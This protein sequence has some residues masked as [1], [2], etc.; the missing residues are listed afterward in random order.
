MEIAE[1]FKALRRHRFLVV[2]VVL[3]AIAAAAGMKL[4]SHSIPTGTATAQILIDSPQSAL[5]DLEQNTA[6]LAVRASVFA[7]LM[8][9]GAVLQ[10]IAQKAGVPPNE[11]TAEGPYSGTGQVLD[12]PT[13]SEA[14]GSQV[15]SAKILYRLTFV[16]QTDLPVI[17]VSAEGPSP[18]AAGRLANSVTP[19]V[20]SWL[21]TVQSNGQVPSGHRVTIRQLGDAQAG[22]IN[23]SSAAA[24][25][26]IAGI[27]VLMVGLL[28]VILVDRSLG[29]RKSA[30]ATGD[31]PPVSLEEARPNLPD[32]VRTPS[33]AT[34]S[35]RGPV[36]VP[37]P[38]PRA[39][40]GEER[41]ASSLENVQSAITR[42]RRTHGPEQLVDPPPP[43][44]DRRASVH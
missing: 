37:S 11:V 35:I 20:E 18:A 9:S 24:L 31:A 36:A 26:G 44:I 1:V 41:R 15:L 40:P 5:A 10:S 42:E 39:N 34:D 23:A 38:G 22:A 21:N 16:A 2:L 28:A 27:A 17:T 33:M 8:T 3:V 19:G 7:Q 29:R 30:R 32:R 14:R 12:V 25:A 6:P 4:S 13:P 43:S